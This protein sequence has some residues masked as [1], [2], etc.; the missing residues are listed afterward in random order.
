LGLNTVIK[1][2]GE[3]RDS[4]PGGASH[5]C[6]LETS[7]YLA[8][9][10]ELVDM[11]QA[12]ADM[13]PYPT[14]SIPAWNDLVAAGPQ[15]P[16]VS[17]GCRT[18]AHS[19]RS[20]CGAIPRKRHG[21][22]ASRSLPPALRAW[23]NSSASFASSRLAS[24]RPPLRAPDHGE[25]T[26]L[27]NEQDRR[28]AVVETLH[29]GGVTT[30]FGIPVFTIS[31]S[32]MPLSQT[33][34]IEHVSAATSKGLGSQ[35]MAMLVRLASPASCYDDCPGAT[36]AFTAVAEAWSESSPA[37]H[38]AS[39]LDAHLVNTER[40]V[41]HEL[42]DQSGTF[43]NVTRHHESVRELERISPPWPSV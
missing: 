9:K 26:D 20:A 6:E 33:P 12:E 1:L 34:S 16:R 15:R 2:F 42:S 8:I 41:I 36:N 39:Q 38:L 17:P 35:P 24:G 23:G 18:G 3:I 37:L 10:P 14:T 4:P 30:V 27:G 40:G 22:R 13:N 32:T 11:S 7:M 19:V 31:R 5:A 21:K 28:E 25:E 43:R 29:A